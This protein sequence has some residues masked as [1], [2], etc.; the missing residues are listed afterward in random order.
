M[1]LAKFAAS[2][3]LLTGLTIAPAAAVSAYA[4]DAGLTPSGNAAAAQ[5]GDVKPTAR[6]GFM[7]A[8]LGAK[9]FDF[10]GFM[11]WLALFGDGIAAIYFVVDCMI[12][13]RPEKIMPASLINNVQSAMAEGD[14]MK[15]L[16]V[17][18]SEP[19]AMAN[20]LSAGFNHVTEGFDVIQESIGAAADLETE[21]MMQRLTWISVCSNLAPML[22]LL[23]TV[24]GM[25][26][27]FATLANGTP[28]VGELAGNISVALWTT[29]GGLVIAI[30]SITAFYAIRNNA[31]RIILRMTALTMELIKGLRGVEVE[32]AEA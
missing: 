21:R 28:D 5:G 32:Q 27:C 9:E 29:A 20:I 10:I 3:A 17:C 7:A 6:T 18:E 16:T 19:G 4:E 31:N 11:L 14:V 22:G 30:P 24:E 2:A 1:K 13:I 8:L 12:L 15:A 26:G 25:I 23:G